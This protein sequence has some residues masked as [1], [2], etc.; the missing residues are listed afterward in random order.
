M[1]ETCG[2]G[3]AFFDF[4]TS[5][6]HCMVAVCGS[7]GFLSPTHPQPAV[8]VAQMVSWLFWKGKWFLDRTLQ[9]QAEF[10]TPKARQNLSLD[11]NCNV[12]TPQQDTSFDFCKCR[13]SPGGEGPR[14]QALASMTSPTRLHLTPNWIALYLRTLLALACWKSSHTWPWIVLMGGKASQVRQCTPNTIPVLQRCVF[15]REIKPDLRTKQ[16]FKSTV[17]FSQRMK[18]G[19]TLKCRR[20]L[21][22]ECMCLCMFHLRRGHPLSTQIICFVQSLRSPHT[23][24]L[25]LCRGNVLSTPHWSPVLSLRTLMAT[26]STAQGCGGSLKDRK[27]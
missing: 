21:C 2:K 14:W 19:R 12:S 8:R 25:S 6:M 1:K 10:S 9:Y 17:Q 23:H 4:L 20:L 5:D 18:I 27:L 22:K 24:S 16:Q 3:I 11:M 26:S 15:D 7:G 13:S